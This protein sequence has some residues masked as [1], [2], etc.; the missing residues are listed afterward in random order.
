MALPGLSLNEE[1]YAFASGRLNALEAKILDLPRLQRLIDAPSVEE[2]LKYLS[3]S[4]YSVEEGADAAL[5]MEIQRL[6][7][8]VFAIVPERSALEVFGLRHLFQHIRAHFRRALPGAS[9]TFTV[10]A[11]WVAGSILEDLEA[12]RYES[13]PPGVREAVMEA[14]AAAVSCD[15]STLDALLDRHLLSLQVRLARDTGS[16]TLVGYFEGTVDT[17]NLSILL[18]GKAREDVDALKYMAEGGTLP[19]AT[20]SR[21]FPAPWEE[22]PSAFGAH[23]LAAVA[24]RGVQGY[25]QGKTFGPLERGTDEYLIGLLGEVK[26]ASLGIGVVARYIV[27]KET[28]VKNVRLILAGKEAGK[29]GS[30]IR[31][32]LRDTNV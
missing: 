18:R 7:Y 6:Y 31:E 3:D 14:A 8:L 9:G 19:L 22:I 4:G 5:A 2:A 29:A 20:Y 28:E 17:A 13:L 21:V 26:Y 25:L 15:A 27:R 32:R 30:Q 11:P 24:A 12:G 23:P 10:G 1:T 16:S